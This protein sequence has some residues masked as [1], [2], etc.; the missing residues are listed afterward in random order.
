MS[1]Q[2]TLQD[3]RNAISS[4]ESE[5][6]H[7]HFNTP[8]GIQGDL[9]GQEAVPVNRFR[10]PA[11]KKDMKTSDTCGRNSIVLFESAS[12]S[13]CLANKLRQ[14]LELSGLTEYR[15]IWKRLV[16]PSGR[17]IY[18]LRA[19]GRR[20]S[21]NDCGGWHSPRQVDYKGFVNQGSG[22][23]NLP[24]LMAQV[25]VAGWPT[26]HCKATGGDIVDQQKAINRYVNP[27]RNN[28]LADA[29]HVAGWATPRAG[30]TT[31]EDQET[32]Q[33]RK[34]KGDVGTMPLTL[35]AQMAGWP[36]AASRDWKDTPGM[37]Q[38]G[39]NPDGSERRRLDMLP[40]V[41]NL[42]GS[43]SQSHAET[44]KSA[45]YQI[46][47]LNPLFSLCYLMG[48]PLYWA[49]AGLRIVSKRKRR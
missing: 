40:R 33:K 19:S 43:Q 23:P 27:E 31:D 24:S 13:Q 28:D 38:T 37:A 47:R 9:F 30:K 39:T 49:M 18:R 20:I 25:H 4:P 15:L 34:D 41:V 17:V 42:A 3:L 11:D 44:G 6:G 45:E 1:N 16:T 8:A 35:Q 2:K 7:L 29:V 46:R 26:P 5:A 48:Y 21:D 36:T 32:W 22:F 14:N 10:V 12:L